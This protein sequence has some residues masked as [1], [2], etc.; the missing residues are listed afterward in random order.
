MAANLK[1][2]K[3]FCV[4][5]PVPLLS[6]RPRVIFGPEYLLHVRLPLLLERLLLQPHLLPPKSEYVLLEGDPVAPQHAPPGPV[7]QGG[8]EEVGQGREAAPPGLSVHHALG[9]VEGLGALKNYGRR[10]GMRQG[11]P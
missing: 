7:A 2:G 3:F 10:K 11:K 5:A 4:E 8:A 1:K 9:N 6:P